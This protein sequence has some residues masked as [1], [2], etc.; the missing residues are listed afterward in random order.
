[1]LVLTVVTVLAAQQDF[2]RWNLLVAMLI[3]AVKASLVALFFMHLKYDNKIYAVVFVGA[4][5][6]LAIFIVLTLFDT[7]YRGEI[8][9][10]R[11]TAIN[12]YAVIY[13]A[14]GNPLPMEER[15]FTR[16]GDS[17]SG[18]EE[19]PFE[20]KHGYGP[21]K[22]VVE[23]GPLD[24]AMAKKGVQIFE[25]KCATCHKLDERYT[26]PPLRGVTAYRSP[27]FIMNQILDPEQNVKNH[28]DMQ[29][30]FKQYYT[31]MTNQNVSREEARILVEYLRWEASKTGINSE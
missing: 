5:S 24:T 22:E 13:D 17:E 25:S 30:M 3:A 27:T 19:V 23:V 1:M 9:E 14:T 18:S 28:P 2:G 11:A 7:L 8:N 26:G 20:L 29:A 21:I 31:M 16:G 15:L 10:V 12:Q 6:F 4:V